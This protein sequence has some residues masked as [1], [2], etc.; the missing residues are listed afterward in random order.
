MILLLL[1]IV[2]QSLIY[3]KVGFDK[4]YIHMDEAYSLG[5]AS[6]DKV[7]IQDNDDFY[8][9]WH[10]GEYYEDYLA[11]NDDEAGDFAPVYN[12]QRNDVHPPLYYLL[13]RIV[14][15]A[16][17]NHFSKWGGI[18]INIVIYA[19]ITIFAYFISLKLMGGKEKDKTRAV[20]L[21]FVSSIT[22]GALTSVIY[23]RM[24]ALAT[25]NIMMITYCTMKLYEKFNWRN[26]VLVGIVAL[27]GSLT[28]Y[29]FLFY[30]AMLFVIM[31]VHY[32]RKK[33][34]KQIAEY[35]ATLAVAGAV[36]L[37]IF[38]YSVQH[39]FFGYRG[40]GVISKLIN[41]A[42]FPEYF[43]NIGKYLSIIQVYVFNSMLV[44]LTVLIIGIYIYR[45]I[46]GVKSRPALGPYFKLLC[47]PTLFYTLLVAVSTPW[48]ELRYVMPVCATLFI[49]VFYW[50]WRLCESVVSMKV[51]GIALCGI[52]AIT[53]VL[54]IFIGPEPQVAYTDKREI[55][56][57][58]QGELNVPTVFWF[59]SN[60][61][62]FLDDILLF[63]LLDES[64]VAKDAS[65]DAETIQGILEGRDLSDGI[66]VFI[67]SGQQNDDVLKA[68]VD[69]TELDSATHLKRMNACDIYYLK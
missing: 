36:S 35:I 38:P 40:D 37:A 56:Q 62:R 8:D 58:V 41:F 5:L 32:A 53:A 10:S 61:N 65:L 14:M 28:H 46:K 68:F 9:T 39:M 51:S 7:E 23:I 55:V 59:N 44:I 1:A 18:A 31:V 16:S 27:V 25:L 21:A 11:V 50:L 26:L 19:F 30:L 15:S 17:P 3:V 29:F 34:W 45:W 48:I 57:Q 12:N 24:Y 54:P 13:L 33:N 47:L 66:L 49:M 4:S 67:N 2:V 60:E 52:L 6:Y 20:L 69:S 43:A 63:S 42:N 64:Y 22:L